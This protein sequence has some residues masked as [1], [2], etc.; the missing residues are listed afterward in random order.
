MNLTYAPVWK[1]APFIRLLVA[2]LTGI[3]LQ[4]Y[5]AAPLTLIL[6]AI[7]FFVL[8]LTGLSF[9]KVPLL[10]RY[11][12]LKAV[13]LMMLIAATGMLLT[14][15]KNITHQRN[16]FGHRYDKGTMVIASLKETPI[17]KNRSFK[18]LADVYALADKGQLF[19]TKGEIIIYFQKDSSL[20]EQI[21]F[22][23][24]ILFNKTLQPIQ[25]AGNPGSFDYKRYSLFQ[26]ITHQVYLTG[27]DF[28]STHGQLQPL[29]QQWLHQCRHKILKILKTHIPGKDEPA[30]AEALLIGYREDLDRDL[31]QQ[32]S[33]TGVIHVIAIS[34]MHL[35]MIY[36]FLV[37]LLKPLQAKAHTKWI[38][39]V[40]IL[41]V[42]WGFTLVSGAGASI[43]RS[44]V[45]F[46]FIVA[47][48]SFSRQVSVYHTL[49]A[50]AFF[51]L[52]ANPFFAWDVGFQ[53]SYAA[54]LSIVI[55]LKPITNWMYFKNKI[56]EAVWKMAAVTLSAQILT[57]PLSIYHFHQLPNLFLLSNLVIV[58]LSGLT[59][60][61][62]IFL[63]MVSFSS[64]VAQFTGNLLHYLIKA[65]NVFISFVNNLPYAVTHNIRVDLVQT[66]L[67]YALLVILAVWL[68]KKKKGLLPYALCITLVFTTTRAIDIILRYRQPILVVY[69]V[70][71]YRALDI[72]KSNHYLFLGD[73][74]V[75]NDHF[76]R[77]FHLRPTR[78]LFRATKKQPATAADFL[79]VSGKNILILNSPGTLPAAGSRHADIIILSG[80]MPF[81]I[82]QL[83]ETFGCRQFIFD[84]SCPAWKTRQWKNECDS[85]HL[86]RH[87]VSE[88]GAF[89]LNL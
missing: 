21:S 27:S 71:Q 75:E 9:L 56:P 7:S 52:C 28:S 68:M 34:G 59:L 46:S 84:S 45:M 53:L 50:S 81:R 3:L 36:G 54:V 41:L 33:N 10:L 15:F 79:S 32:Y 49:A 76:L 39:G 73:P 31:V 29:F 63:C 13:A 40:I 37:I 42:L 87:S 2:L 88:E 38:R 22:G 48:E 74:A 19:K 44:A 51:L 66:I 26:G 23:S 70:P 20:L 58:P 35:A 43:L 57:T 1:E 25:N 17:E 65:M 47:G 62:E 80:N 24:T 67:L 5:T 85:L 86:R 78:H 11:N 4:W 69:N 61:G 72:L 77:N 83:T 55:F 8:T 12:W 6:T 89:V 82:Q 30:I 16:W 18:V 14:Y 64:P 60:Y